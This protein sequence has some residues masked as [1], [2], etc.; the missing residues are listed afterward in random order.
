MQSYSTII[1]R[2]Y[3][4]KKYLYNIISQIFIIQAL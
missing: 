4:K 2:Y 3:E 1:V